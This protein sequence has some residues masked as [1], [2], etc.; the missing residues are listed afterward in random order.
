MR[1][2]DMDDGT[3]SV[4][5]AVQLGGCLMTEYGA[6][7]RAKQ[8]CPKFSM[9]CGDAAEG[10]IHPAL[11]PLPSAMTYLIFDAFESHADDARLRDTQDA[12]LILQ[13]LSAPC[14]KST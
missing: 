4:K 12:I 11:H 13:E 3:A 8:R 5:E 1:H 10:G 6:R 14:G 9:T 7:P 2:G